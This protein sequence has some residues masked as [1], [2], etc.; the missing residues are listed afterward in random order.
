MNRYGSR[1]LPPATRLAIYLRDKFQCQ[2]CGRDLRAARRDEVT[3]D[4]LICRNAGG[5][6][7]PS[8]LVTACRTC[9]SKRQDKTLKEFA[10]DEAQRRIRNAIRRKLNVQLAK[11]LLAA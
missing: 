4:H 6:H 7:C 3:L 5:S 10:S 1:W 2:Y 8:N 9:N 11:G